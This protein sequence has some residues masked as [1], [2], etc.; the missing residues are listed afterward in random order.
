MLTKSNYFFALAAI[1]QLGAL[2]S[3]KR[4]AKYILDHKPVVPVVYQVN[5]SVQTDLKSKDVDKIIND[6]DSILYSRVKNSIA[7]LIY[8]TSKE[9]PERFGH[10]YV[11]AF[12]RYPFSPETIGTVYNAGY[13]IENDVFAY[14]YGK[15]LG[16]H[17]AECDTS[18]TGYGYSIDVT[19]SVSQDDLRIVSV[20]DPEFVGKVK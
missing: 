1:V 13:H 7:K 6:C 17:L 14:K 5:L 9:I 15:Q 3:D 20:S 16:R 19:I 18:K 10:P 2:S 11:Y 4:V 8:K 12:G